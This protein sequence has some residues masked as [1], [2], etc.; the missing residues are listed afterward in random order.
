MLFRTPDDRPWSE[1]TWEEKMAIW[2]R[3]RNL[4]IILGILT[5]AAFFGTPM[6]ALAVREGRLPVRAEAAMALGAVVFI[7]IAVIWTV[8]VVDHFSRKFEE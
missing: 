2:R 8:R 4:D 1:L 7:A 3:Y 5:V 6:V